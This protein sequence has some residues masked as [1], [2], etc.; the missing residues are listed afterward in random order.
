MNAKLFA[1][2]VSA[3]AFAACSNPEPNPDVVTS[4][5]VPGEGETPDYNP[6]EVPEF[7]YNIAP[8]SGERATDKEAYPDNPDLNPGLTQW[9]NVVRVVYNGPEATVTG[10]AEAGVTVRITGANVDL[11]LGGARLVRIVASGSSDCGSLRLTGSYKHLL[12]LDN[13]TLV[14]TDRPAINDQIKKRMF[15]V[16]RGENRL[17]DGADYLTSSEQR[18]GCLFAEDHIVLCG[19]GVLEIKGNYRHGLVTD[20]YLFINPGVTL[21]VTDAAKNAIHVK[22]S[23]EKNDFRGIEMTGGYVYAN[24]S[25]PAGKA[26][27]SDSNIAIR[28]GN[29]KLSASGS[30]AVDADG[31]MSSAACLKSDMNVSVTGGSI[32]LVSPADGGKGITSD[33]VMTINGSRLTIALS[34]N[35]ESG[36]IDSSV[37]KGL[38]AHGSLGISAGSVAI[39]A[40]GAG[41]SAI[42]SDGAVEMTGGLVY[43]YATKNGLKAAA[44]KVSGGVLLCGGGKNSPCEG[45]SVLELTNVDAP[46]ITE[47]LEGQQLKGTFLWPQSMASASLIY[48]L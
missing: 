26:M 38:N 14:A 6:S 19:D 30:P 3:F 22:G 20:G 15:L 46:K 32:S 44:A 23:S 36:E 27:K 11:S 48:K 45:V 21:A 5:I 12:E 24:T 29:L 42:D 37:P 13:L 40:I 25:A 47:I 28:G 35:A 34:G 18:K 17:A 31:L 43:A 33:G 10:A 7:T 39:S 8:Y 2:A 4:I 9:D 16:V 1:A 41:S